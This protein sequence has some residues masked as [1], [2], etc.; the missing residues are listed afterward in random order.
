MSADY[1]KMLKEF[2]ARIKTLEKEA[3]TV[4]GGATQLE[5]RVKD[6]QKTVAKAKADDQDGIEAA[7]NEFDKVLAR[8]EMMHSFVRDLDSQINKVLETRKAIA[9]AIYDSKNKK[10]N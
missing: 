4:T 9:G 6:A 10:R 5:D 7:V 8:Q 2:G 3:R 1:A